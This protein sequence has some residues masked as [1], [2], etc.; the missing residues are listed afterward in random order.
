MTDTGRSDAR[1]RLDDGGRP[2]AFSI[3]I[4][5]NG[6][7]GSVV[8]CLE[9]IE[10]QRDGAEVLVCEPHA[11]REDVQSRFPWAVFMERR[12]ASV[13]IL[14]RDGIER[15]TADI[16]ALTISPMVP[17]PDWLASLRSELKDADV[18]AGA[19]DPGHGLR[20]S[21]FAEYLCRYAKDM[22]PFE[23]HHSLDLPGD[24]CAYRR[25]LLL[26]VRDS[27]GDGFWEPVVNQR[28]AERGARLLHSHSPVVR[29]G[30]SAGWAAFTRQ[31]LVHGRAHGRQR[32]AGFR[33][34]RNAVGVLASPVVPVLLTVR[35]ARELSAR[36]ALGLRPLLAL[37]HILL[38]NVAWALGEA[39]GHLDA[40]R[41][42]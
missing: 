27:Y 41:G 33:R 2:P 39:R 38:F 31:R 24:N 14:W 20:I 1:H 18:V 35:I 34:G 30:R 19:I 36:R 7:A 13:P 11:S 29:Q 3:V 9:A 40:L 26:E 21:D 10:P 25:P 12:D 32:G 22:R 8:R 37:P 17:A 15:S 42:R 16:V 28:L 4:G 5:S 23:S 6:A